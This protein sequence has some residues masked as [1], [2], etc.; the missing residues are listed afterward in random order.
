MKLE[1]ETAKVKCAV[2]TAQEYD[3]VIEYTVDENGNKE[4]RTKYPC[5]QGCIRK[6][7]EE[8]QAKVIT[9]VLGK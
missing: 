7:C 8:C 9:S 3:M 4:A 1:H 6:E 2:Y 5:E